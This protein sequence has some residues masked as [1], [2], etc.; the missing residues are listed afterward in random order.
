MKKIDISPNKRSNTF[1]LHLAKSVVMMQ[2]PT[3][4]VHCLQK[5]KTKIKKNLLEHIKKDK[6]FCNIVLYNTLLKSCI[7][8]LYCTV[9]VLLKTN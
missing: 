4:H 7:Y 2:L 1:R 8:L 9:L 6:H 5:D 3:I